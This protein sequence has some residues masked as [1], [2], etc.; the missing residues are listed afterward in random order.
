MVDRFR[1][2]PGRLLALALASAAFLAVM[3]QSVAMAAD[4]PQDTMSFEQLF[5][6]LQNTPVYKDACT[7]TC[8]GNIAQ[9]KNYA[10][11]IIF[12]H[13]YHQLVACSSCHPRFPH[14]A[15][16]K[17]ERP[18]MKGCFEC[19]GVR[20]GPM[21]KIASDACEDCHVTPKE[22]LRPAFHTFGWAGSE[23]VEP[24]NKE[25]NTKCAM[26]HKPDSC[27]QCHD[28]Q[29]VV[30]SPDSWDYNAGDGCLSCHGNAGLTKA[31]STGFKSFEVSG[32]TDSTH[33]D[34]DCQQCH[35]DYRYD[36]MPQASQVW[37]INAGN[38]CAECHK[39]QED[40]RLSDPVAA[41]DQS[42]HA[43]AIKDGNNNS[44][45]C[46][47]CH[48]GHFIP[49][50]D[51]ELAKQRMHMSSFRT[52]ARCKQHGDEYDTYDD[53][54][55]GKAYK[56]G[57][58]DAPACWSCHESHNVLPKADEKSSVNEANVAKTCG[59]EGCHS[60]TSEQ[61]G[62]SSA[63]LIHTKAAEQEANPLRRL[64]SRITGQ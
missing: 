35:P 29:G 45:T 61:F 38:A 9:T 42:V 52:C 2:R 46:A 24:S 36:D 34:L 21:G 44:A 63:A 53:Y 59:A 57:A 18:S 10:S 17:I 22:R 16:T 11:A 54:Y 62:V 5:Q 3:G 27:T 26:C 19:H 25:F 39:K 64:I 14:R 32:L 33:A 43:A 7:K 50:L 56:A 60:G 23:H 55:H 1:A 28:Q 47:S 20:H 6:R 48:G 13:G 58:Q 12:Q 40:K 41:Y 8:H 49:R 4:A 30:W 37:S 31:S 51:T 15:D